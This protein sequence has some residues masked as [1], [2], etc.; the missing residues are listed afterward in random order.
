MCVQSLRRLN[1]FFHMGAGGLKDKSLLQK[2]NFS[3]Q[4]S[5]RSCRKSSKD[6]QWQ[7]HW[8]C[9]HEANGW[10]WRRRSQ[11]FNMNKKKSHIAFER[12]KTV[13][14]RCHFNALALWKQRLTV[15]YLPCCTSLSL[16]YSLEFI[17]S[18]KHITS[19]TLEQPSLSRPVWLFPRSPWK[20][21]QPP[22]PN[23]KGSL[24]EKSRAGRRQRGYGAAER[25]KKKQKKP[26]CK[27]V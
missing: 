15:I 1:N 3:A 21:S 8:T 24:S 9:K 26:L 14:V 19:L 6:P 5:S 22:S 20:T 27:N 7:S 11:E 25:G 18:G 10:E 16:F 17:T 2:S 4:Q 23:V 13:Q 12:S